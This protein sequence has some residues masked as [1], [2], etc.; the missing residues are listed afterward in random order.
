M[1]WKKNI[2]WKSATDALPPDQPIGLID[3]PDE[4]VG[5]DNGESAEPD[6][7]TDLNGQAGT[8]V[9]TNIMDFFGLGGQTAKPVKRPLEEATS[10][11]AAAT[12]AAASASEGSKRPRAGS[13][14]KLGAA[15]RNAQPPATGSDAGPRPASNPVA[16]SDKQ[17]GGPE[18]K[19]PLASSAVASSRLAAGGNGGGSRELRAS[20]ARTPR[21]KTVRPG[22]RNLG[23]TCYAN[24]VVQALYSC[25]EFRAVVL[26][27]QCW[28]TGH[29][30]ATEKEDAAEE[31]AAGGGGTDGEFAAAVPR[32]LAGLFAQ[33]EELQQKTVANDSPPS[34]RSAGI[35]GLAA[36]GGGGVPPV[37]RPKEFVDGLWKAAGT[38]FPRGQH[39]AQEFLRLLLDAVGEQMRPPP[40]G[41]QTGDESTPAKAGMAAE[42]IALE[43]A[44]SPPPDAV[45]HSSNMVEQ[46]FGGVMRSTTRCL[47]CETDSTKLE[48][49][50]D[51]SLPCSLV[52][53]DSP[54]QL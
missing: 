21:V 40:A 15:A 48:R 24:S 52:R 34:C 14:L 13:R 46:L 2:D 28:Q 38:P 10:D 32:L 29:P 43:P 33:L 17:A 5:A 16:G 42:E 20:P 39:D 22:L 44:A 19:P 50:M 35:G 18:N 9:G 54:I 6:S 31:E 37:V 51:L 23:Y 47:T 53:S 30:D 27:H 3:E 4:P 7:P 26:A 36:T 45:S 1:W 12:S 49:F 8:S 25:S 11:R 41:Q